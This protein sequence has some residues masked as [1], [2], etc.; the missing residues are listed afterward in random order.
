MFGKLT[1]QFQAIPIV[2]SWIED[3]LRRE[4]AEG[5][6]AYV[7]LIEEIQILMWVNCPEL[8]NWFKREWEEVH[9][10]EHVFE[11]VVLMPF[12]GI[13]GQLEDPQRLPDLSELAYEER[14]ARL[15]RWTTVHDAALKLLLK[16]EESWIGSVLSRLDWKAKDR[17][18]R[19]VVSMIAYLNWSFAELATNPRFGG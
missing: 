6:K 9:I 11:W 2:S 19:M 15:S 12:A 10:P 18:G 16:D 3:D 5:D 17:L 13:V 8:L 14:V 4:I 1:E 7:A